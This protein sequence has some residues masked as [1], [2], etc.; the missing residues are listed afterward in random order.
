MKILVLNC[1][2]SSIKYQLLEMTSEQVLAV[3]SIDR[4]GLPDSEFKHYT[5]AT[6]KTV[7][8]LT[9]NNHEQGVEIILNRLVNPTNGI[10]KDR[11]EITAV[12]HRVVHGGEAFSDSVIISEDVIS[13]IEKCSEIAPLHN[14]ANLEGIKATKKFL[15]GTIQ[16]GTFDTAFHQTMPPRAYLY[17]IPYASYENH[18]VRKYG[19]HGSS[20]KYISW[21][22]AETLGY[23]YNKCKIITCHLGNGASLAAIENGKSIDTS[24][25]FT[26]LEG[27]MMGTRCGDLDLGAM[28][29]LMRKEQ[30]ENDSVSQLIKRTD[31]MLNKKSG[32][33][34][35]CGYSDMRDAQSKADAGDER[36]RMALEM[37]SYRVKKYIGSYAAAMG[38]ADIIVFSGG[39][40]ENNTQVRRNVC[41]GLE[42]MGVDFDE[43]INASTR[44]EIKLVTKHDSRTKVIIVPTNEELVIARDTLRLITNHN[45]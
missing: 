44:G 9:V 14:P 37:Y 41:S 28:L 3:G 11:K 18:R 27:L 36:C 15:P 38:G 12:G 42:Y 4:I 22:A 39:I 23:D 1:G 43:K 24:M 19:F 7:E 29:F 13:Q 21:V 20:H 17:P 16:C 10:I 31:D 32:M 45:R 35:V 26:P 6:E 5:F 2:S 33:L 40:G 30:N 34:G 8:T 25:G